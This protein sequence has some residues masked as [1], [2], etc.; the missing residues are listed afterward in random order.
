MIATSSQTPPSAA[1]IRCSARAP[2]STTSC[3]TC[4]NSNWS[5]SSNASPRCSP[6]NR[7]SPILSGP[8]ENE[9]SLE[10]VG[11]ISDDNE[12][13]NLLFHQFSGVPLRLEFGKN[14]S[15][16]RSLRW[17]PAGQGVREIDGGTFVAGGQ[18]RPGFGQQETDLPV[19]DDE[20]RR[21]D[22]E[23]EDA[24]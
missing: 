8:S 7:S 24:T 17:L 13:R 15:L 5:H 6:T 21:H 16:L 14:E 22:F 11:R 4:P 19:R 10:V 9:G 20:R 12:D 2:C 18:W 3:R 23:A 1:P